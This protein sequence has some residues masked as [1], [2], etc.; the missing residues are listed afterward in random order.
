MS[1]FLGTTL[2]GSLLATST[3]PE[4]GQ[5]LH[6]LARAEVFFTALL[7]VVGALI[8]L[9]GWKAYR[10]VVVTNCIALGYWVGNSLV[11][12]AQIATVGAHV[13][14]VLLGVVCWPLMKYAVA[15][16]GGIVGAI[17]GMAFW[18]YFQQ[19]EGLR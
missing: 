9:F 5:L 7:L 1:M 15:L 13:G 14:A 12:K 4:Q 16:C 17:V 19:P 2:P 8:L 3:L 10:W 6:S 18:T 11:D